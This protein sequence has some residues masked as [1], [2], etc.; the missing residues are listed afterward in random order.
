MSRSEAISLYAEG[1]KS[2]LPSEEKIIPSEVLFIYHT[3]I[4]P[5]SEPREKTVETA[6]WALKIA[7][8]EEGLN[9]TP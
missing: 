4:S 2:I 7:L 6:L 3:L 8:E 1:V 9:L 5:E